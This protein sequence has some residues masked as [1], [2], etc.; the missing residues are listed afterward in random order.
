MLIG[1]TDREIAQRLGITESAVSTRANRGRL[2]LRKI[3]EDG[4]FKE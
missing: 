2:L 4:G 1:Y 3:M